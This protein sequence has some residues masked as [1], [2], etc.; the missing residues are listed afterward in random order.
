MIRETATTFTSSSVEILPWGSSFN[1]EW[2]HFHWGT[3]RR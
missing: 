2:A 1:M 3:N